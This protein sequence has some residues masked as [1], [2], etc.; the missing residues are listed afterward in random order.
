VEVSTLRLRWVALAG[1]LVGPVLGIAGQPRIGAL[2]WVYLV[3][4]GLPLLVA[5]ALVV[6]VPSWIG[7]WRL[8]FQRSMSVFVA[9]FVAFMSVI[10]GLFLVGS[11]FWS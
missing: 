4:M 7:I 3:T 1:F 5:A 11:I 8:T 2:L 10:G 6:I 9:L